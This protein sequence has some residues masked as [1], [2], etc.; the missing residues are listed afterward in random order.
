MERKS[1]QVIRNRWSRCVEKVPKCWILGE[2]ACL[3]AVLARVL[4]G[5]MARRVEIEPPIVVLLT[6]WRAGAAIMKLNGQSRFAE[7][8]LDLAVK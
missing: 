5:L 8:I 7:P 4:A 1:G 3:G 2:L 6:V